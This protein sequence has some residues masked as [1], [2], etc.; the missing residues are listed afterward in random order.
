QYS[1]NSGKIAHLDESVKLLI[2]ALGQWQEID[3]N[4]PVWRFNPQRRAYLAKLDLHL[5]FS[6]SSE[7]QKDEYKDLDIH[8]RMGYGYGAGVGDTRGLRISWVL[9]ELGHALHV[10][11]LQFRDRRDLDDA[12][13]L[14]QSALQIRRREGMGI[15]R[16]LTYLVAILLTRRET[17]LGDEAEL[18]EAQAALQEIHERPQE[19]YASTL[20][21]TSLRGRVALMTTST[22]SADGNL[23]E[24]IDVHVS[25]LSQHPTTYYMR[26]TL[27]YTYSIL[28]SRVSNNV[29]SELPLSLIDKALALTPS[30]SPLRL[31][32]LIHSAQ[33]HWQ[34]YQEGG[35]QTEFASAMSMFDEAINLEAA[36]PD[37][38]LDLGMQWLA[39]IL[40][41]RSSSTHNPDEYKRLFEAQR[42]LLALLPN[43]A[44]LGRDV[45]TRLDAAKVFQNLAQTIAIRAPDVPSVVEVL[46][47][48]RSRTDPA[49]KELAKALENE[50]DKK[51]QKEA[52]ELETNWHSRE[53]MREI[54]DWKPTPIFQEERALHRRQELTRFNELVENARKVPGCER[55]MMP[56]SFD[57][58]GKAGDHVG[59]YSGEEKSL[60]L[61]LNTS[62]SELQDLCGSH[63]EAYLSSRSAE[64]SLREERRPVVKTPDPKAA[65][66][67]KFYH[68]LK[69]LWMNVVS[70]V[71]LALGLKCDQEEVEAKNRP[72]LWW[73][74][75]GPFAF[76]PLH[77]AGI[78]NRFDPDSKAECCSDF[79]VSS[80]TPSLGSLNNARHDIQAVSAMA[81]CV[82]LIAEPAAPNHPRIPH[83]AAEIEAIKKLVPG[84]HILHGSNGTE[85]PAVEA[86]LN[87]LPSTSILHLACHGHQD[88]RAPLASGF[89]LSDGRLKV[90]EIMKLNLKKAVFAFLSACESAAG[91]R[92]Q[93]D[94]SIHLSAALLFAGFRSIVGTLWSMDDAD[95][96]EVARVVYS[97]MFKDGKCNY[98]AIPYALDLAEY[99]P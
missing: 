15:I 32:M 57:E 19:D 3:P 13:K 83:T 62:F 52:W 5:G 28:A 26:P 80:Y 90:S 41:N 58:L 97:E 61:P 86:V 38:R 16:I 34:Y 81:P 50:W 69:V 20:L 76:L 35:T 72:R 6:Y 70:P 10:R 44:S 88:E 89:I 67:S 87:S 93:P 17:T 46:E 75:T 43:V 39:S 25:A 9:S 42:S 14:V 65:S 78:Y 18:A 73:C 27:L 82:Q 8:S 2:E 59:S 33:L 48:G 4:L 12:L 60:R 84:Q 77:A 99:E 49:L 29:L 66:K 96:P 51:V 54:F 95:G 64:R 23:K 92:G 45:Q 30:N 98:D 68:V 85:R 63:R 40:E 91:D 11:Y 21:A 55:L 1:F 94:E 53:T 37:A 79:V 31:Q 74:P 7:G 47:Q 22:N 36:G 71:L 56:D 24:A